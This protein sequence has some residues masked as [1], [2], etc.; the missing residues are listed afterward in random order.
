M[1]AKTLI[2][3]ELSRGKAMII[4]DLNYMEM[5]EANVEGGYYFGPSS[6]TFVFAKIREDLKINKA[7]TSKVDVKGNFAGAQ[8]NADAMGKNTAT[9]AISA[10]TTIEGVGSSS[11]ATSLSASEGAK[12]K[13]PW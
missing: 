4:S 8:A 12:F 2:N 10:T 1:S 7:F 9:Q 5:A 11:V 6:K 13:F 3:N